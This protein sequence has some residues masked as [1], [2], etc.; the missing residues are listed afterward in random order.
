MLTPAWGQTHDA[1]SG[2][3]GYGD[4]RDCQGRAE[5]R[6]SADGRSHTSGATACWSPRQMRCPTAGTRT[7]I[8]CRRRPAERSFGPG[9]LAMKLNAAETEIGIRANQLDAWR[10]FT[11]ALIATMTPPWLQSGHEGGTP[12]RG[13]QERA[14]RARAASRRQRHRARPARRRP[15]QG[16][17]SS[18][19][20]AD[21]G[22]AR[23]GC[24][25]RGE[26]RPAPWRT[27]DLG[28]RIMAVRA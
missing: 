21:A 14:F 1:S 26:A 15:R 12:A 23:Q 4:D 24:R 11:D 13:A 2:W 8:S 3:D 18:E 22:A 7:E 28:R 6:R 20:Q 16:D 19:E 9:R 5:T 10:D 27:G 17:R 25:D